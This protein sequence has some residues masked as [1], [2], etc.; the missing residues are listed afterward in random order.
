[1]NQGKRQGRP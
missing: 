1:M